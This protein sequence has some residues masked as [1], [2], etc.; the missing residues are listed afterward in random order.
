MAGD[1]GAGDVS[2][3]SEH[4]D[5]PRPGNLKPPPATKDA[6]AVALSGGDEPGDVPRVVAGGRG[7]IA[8]QILEIAF[9]KG[10]RVRED[11]DLAELLSAIDVDE[12]IPIEAFA[13]VAEIL[14]YVYRA[15]GEM[16]RGT[17]TP[18]AT[19]WAAGRDSA[20]GEER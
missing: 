19:D 17:E 14:A 18:D 9:Q 8:E 5:P 4:D 11:K 7:R 13:A 16:R 2:P 10:V 1:G 15:N 20:A 6:M 3:S 12:E